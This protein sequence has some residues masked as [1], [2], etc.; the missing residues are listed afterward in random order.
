MLI[1]YN[2]PFWALFLPG[3]DGAETGNPYRIPVHVL[4]EGD[5]HVKVGCFLDNLRIQADP[6]GTRNPRRIRHHL[7]V[8]DG[9]VRPPGAWESKADKE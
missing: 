4:D 8:P 5:V 7:K 1:L 2:C 3:A 9:H 6:D